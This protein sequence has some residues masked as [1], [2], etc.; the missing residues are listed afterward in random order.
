MS[1]GTF[2]NFNPA[3]P[4]MDDNESYLVT[5]YEVTCDSSVYTAAHKVNDGRKE[6]MLAQQVRRTDK[7]NSKKGSKYILADQTK[8]YRN[9]LITIFLD[10]ADSG[11]SFINLRPPRLKNDNKTVEKSLKSS[12]FTQT[13]IIFLSSPKYHE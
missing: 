11:F 8:R 9:R 12:S 10:A 4:N 1:G 5:G 2:I 3:N 7:P 6:Y 13:F